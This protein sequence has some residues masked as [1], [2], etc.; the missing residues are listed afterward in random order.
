MSTSNDLLSSFLFLFS[1]FCLPPFIFIFFVLFLSFKQQSSFVLFCPC[2]SS[3]LLGVVLPVQQVSVPLQ[4][5][6]CSSGNCSLSCPFRS[7][8]IAFF[9]T[10]VVCFALFAFFVSISS[11]LFSFFSFFLYSGLFCCVLV[12]GTLG[13]HLFYL[14]ELRLFG[15]LCFTVVCDNII[16]ISVG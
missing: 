13:L 9:R 5:V 10:P 15:L 1:S 16:G 14:D 8:C 7:S 2:N 6:W 3:C 11:F 4:H 12:P